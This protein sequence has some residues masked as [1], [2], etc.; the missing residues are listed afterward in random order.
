MNKTMK[1]CTF[2]YICIKL[3]SY[4]HRQRTTSQTKCE[5]MQISEKKVEKA[6]NTI[7]KCHQFFGFFAF[8]VLVLGSVS[9]LLFPSVPH[10]T[11]LW[12]FF[13]CSFLRNKH[14][15]IYIIIIRRNFP[16]FC[17]HFSPVQKI[18]M[19]FSIRFS[20]LLLQKM[21]FQLLFEQWANFSVFFFS[22]NLTGFILS[23]CKL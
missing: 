2:V 10:P 14:T 5:Y 16:L 21:H 22:F 19:H 1:L 23:Q 20:F 6:E 8:M 11:F 4:T 13:H 18:F 3:L 9:A 17:F 12:V 15:S 7:Y